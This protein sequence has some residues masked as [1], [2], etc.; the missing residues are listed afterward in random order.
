MGR[1][2]VTKAAEL[3]LDAR[4]DAGLTQTDLARR[5]R[6]SQ[7]NLAQMEAGKRMPSEEM[8]ERILGAADYRPSIPVERYA[9]RI[10]ELAERRGL[11]NP[12]VFGSVV[13]GEDH[14]DSDIDLLVSPSPQTSLFTLAA[15]AA[16]IEELTG[17][18]A[19]VV[20]ESAAPTSGAAASIVRE[21]IPL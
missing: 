13:R 14:F 6:I 5:A 3:I 19:D 12:R 21:A 7:P 17:F 15:L 16:D 2:D 8:L 20:A 1:F 18:P 11:R 10:R 4:R 9:S